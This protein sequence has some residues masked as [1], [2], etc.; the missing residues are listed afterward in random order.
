[1]KEGAKVM[2]Y[3]KTWIDNEG[4]YCGDCRDNWQS[5]KQKF[6][7]E[8]PEFIYCKEFEIKLIMKN[9]KAFRC[10]QCL[11]AEVKG[12]LTDMLT[13]YLCRER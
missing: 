8:S 3:I 10:K 7:S 13:H 6:S 5:S 2:A 11:D 9:G 12:K 1:M 4:K